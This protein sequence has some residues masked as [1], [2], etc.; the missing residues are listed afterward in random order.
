[1]PNESDILECLKSIIDPDFQRDIVSLGFVKQLKVKG[2]NV[3]FDI[4]LTTPA[5]PHADQFRERATQAVVA[6]DGVSQVHVRMTSRPRPERKLAEGSGLKGI[7][8]MLAVSSCKGGVGK[9]TVA[10]MLACSLAERGHAVGLLDADIFG[11]SVPSLFNEHDSGV[12]ADQNG[13]IQPR[14]V[15]GL[16]LMSF[17]FMAGDKPAV[18]RGPMVANF[19]QQMLHNVNW[20]NLDYLIIDMPP[21]TGDIQLTIS[22]TAQID[23][24]VIVTTPHQLS[25]ADVRKGILMFDKVNVPVIGVIENMAYFVCASCDERHEIFGPPASQQ[26][27]DRFG[28]PTLAQLPITTSMSASLQEITRTP[29]ASDA[30]DSVMRA[31]G[32][33]TLKHQ[34]RPEVMCNETIITLLWPDSTTHSVLNRDLRLACQCALCI[35]EMSRQPILD[36]DTIPPDIHATNIT[37]IGNYAIAIDWSDGHNTGFFPYSQIRTLAENESAPHRDR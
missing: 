34:P 7:G 16:K 28:I 36:P 3:S 8:C 15:N 12:E 25:L 5:C 18:M 10:A 31:L 27:M 24:S 9:S 13:Y 29:Y 21:G 32:T 11:P 23:A 20:G 2:A 30:T 33:Q 37:P 17:G 19:I 6:L 26:L 35:D 22:Q 1:M 4:E 14:E